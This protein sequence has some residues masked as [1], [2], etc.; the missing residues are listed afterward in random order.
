M[1]DL[2]QIVGGARGDN[3]RTRGLAFA[4]RSDVHVERRIGRL[5][6]AL[7]RNCRT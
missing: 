6:D 7:D 5:K 2:D 4:M 3:M 1:L